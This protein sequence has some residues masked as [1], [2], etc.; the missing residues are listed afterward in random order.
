MG[1]PDAL[2]PESVSMFCSARCPGDVVLKTFDLARAL[3]DAGTPVFGGFHT[4]MERE[5]L[6]LLL[7]G[8]QPVVVCPAR[9]IYN[10]R[11]PSAWRPALDD[12]RL[13]ILS[14][15]PAERRRAT[16]ALCAERNE[17]SGQILPELGN[18]A[19]LNWL[20]LS[21]NQLSGEIPSELDDLANLY[22]LRISG[23]QLGG[24]IPERLRNVSDNDL[25][26]LDV[27]GCGGG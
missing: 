6:R 10:M 21:V 5:C 3:R 16:A 19:N 26:D 22:S 25:D 2:R 1:N 13:L 11:I 12:G 15:F 20:N 7:R 17:L 9:S 24:C 23:S 8:Q 18:L 14:P 4:P 27:P